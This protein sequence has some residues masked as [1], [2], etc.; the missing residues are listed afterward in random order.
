MSVTAVRFLTY[1]AH[2]A[3]PLTVESVDQ[4]EHDCG[5]CGTVKVA[6]LLL[7]DCVACGRT[8]E[9]GLVVEGPD[10]DD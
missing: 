10:G 9:I 4:A 6:V 1:C 5:E 2:C 8:T 3:R 7:G